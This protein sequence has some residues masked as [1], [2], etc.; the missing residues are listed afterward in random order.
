MELHDAV[1]N[2]HVPTKC[3]TVQGIPTSPTSQYKNP[4]MLRTSRWLFPPRP[5]C[6][7]ELSRGLWWQSGSQGIARA[8]PAVAASFVPPGVLVMPTCGVAGGRGWDGHTAGSHNQWTTF[9]QRCTHRPSQSTGH[10]MTLLTAMSAGRERGT[11]WGGTDRFDWNTST[12]RFGW[13]TRWLQ[14][15]SLW[16]KQL[17]Y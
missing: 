12:Y 14:S 11:G 7:T 13:N 9:R 4:L 17:F 5:S 16:G 6:G 8:H 10:W 2:E 1:K 15:Q 3:H